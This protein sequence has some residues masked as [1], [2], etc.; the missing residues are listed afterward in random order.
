MT[1]QVKVLG[2]Q[3]EGVTAGQPTH[4]NIDTRQAGG[5][6]PEVSVSSQISASFSQVAGMQNQLIFIDSDCD[7]DP[8]LERVNPTQSPMG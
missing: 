4:F 6:P 3:C 2:A 5:A 1:V 8:D 7:C